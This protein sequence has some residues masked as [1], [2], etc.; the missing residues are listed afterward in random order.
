MSVLFIHLFTSRKNAEGQSLL[1]AIAK[2]IGTLAPTIL[3]GIIE[4]NIVVLTAGLFCSVFD[5]IYII[6]LMKEKEMCHE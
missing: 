6:L 2:W 1:L 5:I 4:F 3:M